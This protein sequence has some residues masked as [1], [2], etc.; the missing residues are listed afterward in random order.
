MPLV[1]WLTTSCQQYQ[2]DRRRSSAGQCDGEPPQNL[3][4]RRRQ[5]VVDQRDGEVV[6]LA[7]GD[8]GAEDGQDEKAVG[9][10]FL[11]GREREI[12]EIAHEH[13]GEA[14]Q[15][16]CPETGTTQMIFTAAAG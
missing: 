16:L 3:A 1:C 13:I 5:Q 15:G 4:Q 14:K 7:G 11:G 6:A 9:Q 8:G 10:Q 2:A 12:G